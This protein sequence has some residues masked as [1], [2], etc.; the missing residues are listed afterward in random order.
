MARKPKATNDKPV[1]NDEP[2]FGSSQDVVIRDV[3]TGKSISFSEL[4]VKSQVRLII[5]GA[6]EILTDSGAFSKEQVA[7]FTDEG[8]L[9][10]KKA[11]A[12][13]KRWNSLLTGEFSVGV[14]GPRVDESTR[15][16]NECLTESFKAYWQAQRA[17]GAKVPAWADLKAESLK[18]LLG[19]WANHTGKDGRSMGEVAR[20]QADRRIAEAKATREAVS[21]DFDLTA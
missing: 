3:V 17:S 14:R 19:R 8:V 10:A 12:R 11:E 16:Y 18:G 20:E 6:N 9:E 2:E 1:A 5:K 21:A 15:V 7:K 13:E 4:P